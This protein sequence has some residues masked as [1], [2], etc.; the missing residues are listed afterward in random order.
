MSKFV[1]RIPVDVD[2]VKRLLP[3]RSYVTCVGL[4]PDKDA[5][6]VFWDDDDF[7]TGYT[8][9]VEFSTELLEARKL[10]DKVKLRKGAAAPVPTTKHERV[11]RGRVGRGK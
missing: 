7:E 11:A 1:T 6:E 4:H 9:P 8:F 3:K 5:V 10:P 2:A